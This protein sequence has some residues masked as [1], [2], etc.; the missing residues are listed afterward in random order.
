M[1]KIV[2]IGASGFIGSYL[3]N[4]LSGRYEIIP[5]FK[6]TLDLF[7]FE[8]VLSFLKQTKPN[9]IINCLSFGG[10][11]K[12]RN[13]D[14]SDI[15]KNLIFFSNFYRLS[16][17]Y[18]L[19]INIGS[20]SEFDLSTNIQLA[21]EEEIFSRNPKESYAFSKNIISRLIYGNDKFT[22]LRLF[23]C[24]GSNEPDIR[25]LKRYIQSKEQFKI[26]NNRYFDYFSIQ[27]FGKVVNFVIE[28]EI[29]GC[30]INCVYKEKL[31]LNEFLSLFCKV[32]GVKENF[33][34]NSINELNYTGN[35]M[36]LLK[37]YLKL[38]GIEKGLHQW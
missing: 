11:E 15:H 4:N 10:K 1:K 34:V 17:L 30:D 25:F 36:H 33:V 5:I 38:D 32:K 7:N 12:V 3:K 13:E 6:D 35:Y 23:G 31:M 20:G 27:D 8:E 29:Q 24:F 14:P 26:E 18:D 16:E 37:M 2:I 9:I 22:T 21:R 19:Y 28:N